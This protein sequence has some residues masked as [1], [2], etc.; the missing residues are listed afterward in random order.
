MEKV[1]KSLVAFANGF[2]VLSK[3]VIV[4]GKG[5]NGR[6]DPYKL[7]FVFKKGF[8]DGFPSNKEV[9]TSKRK[10]T[11][12]MKFSNCWKHVTFI[13]KGDRERMKVQS[14]LISVAVAVDLE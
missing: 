9:S 14:D 10:F 11:T 12:I 2:I 6:P 4:G 13:S 8:K 5:D 7:L 1:G 3:K